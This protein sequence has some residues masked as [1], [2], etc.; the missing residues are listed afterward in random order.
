MAFYVKWNFDDY[1][2]GVDEL[3]Q[4]GSEKNMFVN[5]AKVNHLID[6]KHPSD[7]IALLI[8][9]LEVDNS[10]LVNRLKLAQLYCESCKHDY[11]N[12]E[13]ALWEL[14]SIL[15]M[16]ST[17]VPAQVLLNDLNEFLSVKPQ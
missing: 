12:C 4:I 6:Q 7:A 13:E 5:Q 1:Q 11:L 15:E 17:I 8:K 16:D 9:M 14:N 10:N 3:N 2:K